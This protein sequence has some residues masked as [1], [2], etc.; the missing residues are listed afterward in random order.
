MY[1]RWS[2]ISS[3]EYDSRTFD[4]YLN[5][6]NMMTN[7]TYHRLIQEDISLVIFNRAP[8][9]GGDFIL[10]LL[11]EKMKIRTL[12]MESSIFPNRFF[13]TFDNADFG[14][15]KTCH[16]LYPY[17][18]QTIENKFEKVL[19]Y[20]RRGIE[21]KKTFQEKLHSKFNKEYRLLKEL[22]SKE[23]FS[24][25]FHRYI[26]KRNYEENIRKTEKK[27]PDLNINYVYFP[28]HLQPEKTTSAWGGK[29]SD[30]LLALEKLSDFIPPGWTIY[31]KENPKQNHVMRGRYFFERLAR[32]PKVKLVKK[33]LD[34]YELLRRSQFVA[35]ITGTVGWEAISGGKNVLIFGWGAWYRSLPG[36]F[37]YS[38]GLEIKDLL[39]Y[40]IDHGL[41]EK[42]YA[43]LLTKMGKGVIYLAYRELYTHFDDQK[44]LEQV[45]HEMKRILY[46]EM[47]IQ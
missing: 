6:F 14:S 43:N 26:L 45:I 23:N 31:V 36:V 4:D 18:L 28:L 25:A 12:I 40:K 2:P 42:E 47:Q 32:I 8:H 35:T 9:L 37:Y 3:R 22:F 13:Y 1:T 44:N 41:L 10:Y 15:F 20:M 27:D 17:R 46:P 24:Q 29:F 38:S 39:N 7:Y 16:Q 19:L 34:T 30:Q 33:E 5:I 21:N 11:A